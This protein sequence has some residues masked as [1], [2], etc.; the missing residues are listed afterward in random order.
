MERE[1]S[2]L[3][4][5]LLHPGVLLL[6][7][8]LA[9]YAIRSCRLLFNILAVS[10]PLLCSA[11]LL[12]LSPQNQIYYFNYI[13]TISAEY[14]DSNIT[15]C[16]YTLIYTS[17]INLSLWYY[18]ARNYYITIILST[19]YVAFNLISLLSAD[20]V[21][22]IY[23]FEII[24]IISAIMLF[25]RSS[26]EKIKLFY[27]CLTVYCCSN[28]IVL[29]GTMIIVEYHG[30]PIISLAQLIISN[31]SN[32]TYIACML[33]LFG[34]FLRIGFPILT[35]RLVL[36][37]YSKSETPIGTYFSMFNVVL[38]IIWI[39]R[40]FHGLGDI[41]LFTG[42]F[43]AVYGIQHAALEG[44]IKRSFSFLL[45]GIGGILLILIGTFKNPNEIIS[46]VTIICTT[47]I[48]LHAFLMII[49]N[50]LHTKYKILKFS[51]FENI[52]NIN[53]ILPISIY[54]AIFSTMI[55]S[56][57]I[58]LGT[59]CSLVI[60]VLWKVPIIHWYKLR[61]SISFYKLILPNDAEQKLYLLEYFV[62]FC[63]MIISPIMLIKCCTILLVN[64][65]L[66]ASL[67]AICIGGITC[68]GFERLFSLHKKQSYNIASCVLLL[69]DYIY[70]Y[71][72]KKY[73]WL[74]HLC[75]CWTNHA[76]QQATNL[77][78]F[79]WHLNYANSPLTQHRLS[80]VY[81]ILLL[82]VLIMSSV[83]LL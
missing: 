3:T 48:L 51:D 83:I 45:T 12:Y 52:G 67:I 17:I 78:K 21:T 38:N 65:N 5:I 76:C 64:I 40:L 34:L 11:I 60:V 28:M 49:C 50:L 77:L 72:C 7:S 15:L 27:Q 32:H 54:F 80:I 23:T 22:M 10:C 58:L 75:G 2:N 47:Y 29:A 19:A 4:E 9:L 57:C 61:N 82:V 56:A 62:I 24:S 1:Y 35:Y 18:N 81:T 39:S 33:I 13:I 69:E 63:F 42:I 44:Q 66:L 25:D 36:N 73:D 55:V 16:V 14:T 31:N 46:T 59:I 68:F 20:F 79:R 53:P 26:I 41:I 74:Y 43:I 37:S 8:S 30:L 71:C 70:E 6:L